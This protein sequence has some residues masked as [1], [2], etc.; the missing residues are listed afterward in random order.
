MGTDLT[1]TNL[2][3]DVGTLYAFLLVLARISGAFI[4][5]P[6]PGIQAGP[7]IAR[8]VLSASLTLAL[9]SRWPVIDPDGVS[10]PLLMGWMLAEAAMG[11]AVGLAVAFL[12]EGFQ[13]GA[14]IISLQAGYSFASTIDPTSGA[15]S[16]VLIM[17]AQTTAGLLFFATGMDRQILRAFADSLTAYP[18][19]HFALS[20]PMVTRMIQAGSSIFST[21]LRLVLPLLAL[22][23]MVEISLALLTRLN[24]QLQLMQIS[25]PLK[26]LLSLTLLGWLLLI[27]PQVFA[28][29]ANRAMQLVNSLL[30]A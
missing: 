6:I 23:L 21:G 5:V 2:T 1:G 25:M 20:V 28:Q 4:F 13:M 24:S 16:T 17:I 22:L 15:D 7:Q 27:F 9:H 8:A 11:L 3:I 29:S 12:I 30:A 26:M 19:G 14:Q 18:P 10:F